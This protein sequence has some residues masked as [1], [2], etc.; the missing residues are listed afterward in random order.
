MTFEDEFARDLA[1]RKQV[2][3]MATSAL[4]ELEN[5][6]LADDH[7]AGAKLEAAFVHSMAENESQESHLSPERDDN[8]HGITPFPQH[9][10]EH[11]SQ[12]A[13]L[14]AD[15]E[16]Q[17][18]ALG[19][20]E[21]LPAMDPGAALFAKLGMR[22]RIDPSMPVD[23]IRMEAQECPTPNSTTS[24]ETPSPVDSKPS[25]PTSSVVKTSRKPKRNTNKASRGKERR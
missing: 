3:L 24:S 2:N 8:P 13:S 6:C 25:P 5:D 9:E 15:A 4:L 1:L 21:T 7:D 11:E 17:A 19:E 14:D 16:A 18:E 23:G 12:D 22:V 20:G 10:A